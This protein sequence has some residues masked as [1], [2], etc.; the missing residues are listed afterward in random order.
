M[1]KDAL[2]SICMPLGLMVLLVWGGYLCSR[3]DHFEQSTKGPCRDV[4]FELHNGDSV[5]CA[6]ASTLEREGSAFVTCRCPRAAAKPVQAPPA[7]PK[8]APAAAAPDKP[9][10]TIVV[11]QSQPDLVTPVLVHHGLK[12]LLGH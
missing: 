5:T 9:P 1:S 8:P 7:S 11:E 6:A 2:L 10:Q 12:L 3:S 4:V